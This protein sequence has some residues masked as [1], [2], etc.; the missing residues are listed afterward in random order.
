M[1]IY[2]FIGLINPE[3]TLSPYEYERHQSN[4][5][6]IKNLP[7]DK[8]PTTDDEITKL[9]QTSYRSALRIEQ[10]KKIQFLTEIVILIIL[11]IITFIAHWT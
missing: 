8:I 11:A 7:K 6:F 1:A 4:D 9:R 5:L 2:N 3:F 10:H